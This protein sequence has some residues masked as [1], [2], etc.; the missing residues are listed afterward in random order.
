MGELG[1]QLGGLRQA[2][3]V[4]DYHRGGV[5]GL[6]SAVAGTHV[7]HCDRSLFSVAVNTTP[8]RVEEN[9][10]ALSQL[11]A[12]VPDRKSGKDYGI[13]SRGI[14]AVDSVNE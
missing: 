13:L 11:L 6:V 4:Q 12:G 10:E 1:E 2:A 7:A 14:V 5:E 3:T 9:L 8:G